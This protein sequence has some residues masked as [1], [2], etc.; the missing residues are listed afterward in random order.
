[1]DVFDGDYLKADNAWEELVWIWWHTDAP[2]PCK[3]E[4]ID[5]LVTVAPFAGNA[6]QALA[7]GVQQRLYEVIPQDWDVHQWLG[8]ATPS[9]L[10]LYVPDLA[11]VPHRELREG[12]DD[13]VS[14]S[15]AELVVEITSPATAHH[16]RTAKA[17]GYAAAGVPL[18]LLIDGLAPGGPTVTLHGG[19]ENGVYRSLCAKGSGESVTLPQPF[20]LVLD[21][22][23]SLLG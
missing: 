8:T 20:D 10:G 11:V 2:K 16:D 15:T 18:Y 22:D 21:A 17:A 3:V 19:P 14:A 9:R 12:D 5:G 4:I 6:H 23:A 13:F 1:M 7:A